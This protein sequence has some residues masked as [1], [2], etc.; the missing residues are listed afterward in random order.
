M[1][2]NSSNTIS[3][4]A[5]WTG[6]MIGGFTT[7]F[8]LVDA[9]AKLITPPAVV[10]A[11][12]ALG[13]DDGV[14]VTLGAVLLCCTVLYLVPRTAVLGAILLTGYLGGAVASHVRV[15]NPVATHMLFPVYLGVLLWVAL[16]LHNLEFRRLVTLRRK[17][18]PAEK[19]RCAAVMD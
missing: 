17:V 7:L 15:G 12:V 9:V 1:N 10:E 14:V 6:R 3:R 13:Y 5:R 18:A 16:F 11:T 19:V 2:L 8:L 4:G